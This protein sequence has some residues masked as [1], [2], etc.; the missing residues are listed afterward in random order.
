MKPTYISYIFCADLVLKMNFFNFGA[1]TH[2]VPSSSKHLF[3]LLGSA[4]LVSK[5]PDVYQMRLINQFTYFVDHFTFSVP[6]V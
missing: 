4:Y 6:T 2:Y 3:F 5:M 1:K